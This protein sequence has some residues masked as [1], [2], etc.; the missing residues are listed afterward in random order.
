MSFSLGR[1]IES[2]LFL[3]QYMRAMIY[4]INNVPVHFISKYFSVY[5]YSFRV[6]MSE[7]CSRGDNHFI[8][9]VSADQYKMMFKK[10]KAK[11]LSTHYG[12]MDD[13]SYAYG[14]T[15]YTE[16]SKYI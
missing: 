8:N 11:Y 14:F 5:P 12:M 10:I 6:F 1:K 4:D 7:E 9:S 15:A 16:D 13:F 2:E 3:Q